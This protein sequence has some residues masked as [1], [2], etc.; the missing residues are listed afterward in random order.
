MFLGGSALSSQQLGDPA[1][2]LVRSF[3]ETSYRFSWSV[4]IE[5]NDIGVYGAAIEGLEVGWIGMLLCSDETL[6][7]FIHFDNGVTSR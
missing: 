1:S 7:V 2:D 6:P 3:G 5:I 4:N